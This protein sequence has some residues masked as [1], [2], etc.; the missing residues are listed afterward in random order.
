MAL[1]TDRN[2]EKDLSERL[3]EF[4]QF[5]MVLNYMLDI[6]KIDLADLEKIFF[7]SDREKA[8]LIY[9]GLLKGIEP[10]YFED[11]YLQYSMSFPNNDNLDSTE[12]A[13]FINKC[14]ISN[15]INRIS[16]KDKLD[17]TYVNT[18]DYLLKGDNSCLRK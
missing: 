4:I 3:S 12:Y 8:I 6:G 7:D 18:Y 10:N 17:R 9:S 1:L 2:T 14:C 11:S 13:R 5:G 15:M 16:E